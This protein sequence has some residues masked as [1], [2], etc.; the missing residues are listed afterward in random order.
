MILYVNKLK[1]STDIIMVKIIQ[2]F[3]FVI[4]YTVYYIHIHVF[5][6]ALCFDGS[7]KKCECVA[8]IDP[9]VRKTKTTYSPDKEEAFMF[10]KGQATQIMPLMIGLDKM[11]SELTKSKALKF[12][13]TTN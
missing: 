2:T 7:L 10:G 11:Y 8:A 1:N 4:S 5:G 6:Q 13:A 9:G 12:Q 3:I